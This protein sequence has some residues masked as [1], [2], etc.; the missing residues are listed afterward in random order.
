MRW[1]PD[2]PW[3]PPPPDPPP[4]PPR[5]GGIKTYCACMCPGCTAALKTHCGGADCA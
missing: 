4:L 3:T 5:P 2:P 1:I